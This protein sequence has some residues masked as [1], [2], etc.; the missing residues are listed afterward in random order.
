M[1]GRLF[2]MI[3]GGL[4]TLAAAYIGKHYLNLPSFSWVTINLTLSPKK[5]PEMLEAEKRATEAQRR[6]EEALAAAKRQ[7]EEAR[8]EAE[9]N[10]RKL[11][12]A[13][14]AAELAAAKR[15]MQEQAE[16]EAER[17][18]L[19]AERAALELEAAK[20]RRRDAAEAERLERARRI[21]EWRKA[22]G[23]CDPPLRRQC[24]TIGPTG[25]GPQQ[26]IGCV[27]I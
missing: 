12:A 15:R 9:A 3:V 4:I 20:K 25:G 2:I 17:R 24:M 19:E 21:Q 11:E 16:A 14:A 18:K 23:G 6:H 1:I 27:C 13:R 8:A 7:E 10:K 26:S 22:N 5:S